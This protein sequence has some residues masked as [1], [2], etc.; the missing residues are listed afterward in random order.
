MPN[1]PNVGFECNKKA[2]AS[3]IFELF[4]PFSCCSYSVGCN[5]STIKHKYFMK[6]N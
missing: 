1:M 5:R 3:D 2:G 6:E 4:D